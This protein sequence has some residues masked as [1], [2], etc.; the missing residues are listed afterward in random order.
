[1]LARRPTPDPSVRRPAVA[2]VFYPADPVD[3]ADDVDRLLS[4]A[5]ARDDLPPRRTNA[6]VALVVPHA[7]YV[8]SGMTAAAG[9]RLVVGRSF[10]RV[11][12]LGPSHRV[13][14]SGLASASHAAFETPLGQ[15]PLAPVPPGV[16]VS[17]GVHRDEHSLEV[18]LPFLQRSLL[19]DWSLLPICVGQWDGDYDGAAST[20]DQPERVLEAV[21]ALIAPGTLIVVSSDLSHYEPIDVARELDRRTA[22]AILDR[23]A[24]AIGTADACGCHALRLLLRLAARRA[25]SVEMEDLRTSGDTAGGPDRV[26]GYGA[27]ACYASG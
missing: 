11:V 25:W 10:D 6:P 3:L 16:P 1:M 13:W 9:Y 20:T 8:Y 15:V 12:L 21:D 27:F 5:D 14:L 7:G 22:A 4:Q 26:V 19:D 17:A 24:N 18:Q 23:D 2:G